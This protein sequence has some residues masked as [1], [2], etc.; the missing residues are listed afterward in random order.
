MEILKIMLQMNG[1]GGPFGRRGSLIHSYLAG[2]AKSTPAR[3]SDLSPSAS[4]LLGFPF[5]MGKRQQ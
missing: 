5:M 4:L 3:L 2:V 1:H